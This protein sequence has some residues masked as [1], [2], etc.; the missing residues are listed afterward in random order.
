MPPE[1][2]LPPAEPPQLPGLTKQRARGP[3]RRRPSP[4]LSQ[5]PGGEQPRT[6]SCPPADSDPARFAWGRDPSIDPALFFSDVVGRSMGDERSSNGSVWAADR[7]LGSIAE[8]D[9]GR[10]SVGSGEGGGDGSEGVVERTKNGSGS[11]VARSSMGSNRLSE[12]AKRAS[13]GSEAKRVSTGSEE[14]RSKDSESKSGR[15]QIGSA[16]EAGGE[17]AAAGGPERPVS[18]VSAG[19]ESPVLRLTGG[20]VEGA[21]RRRLCTIL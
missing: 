18:G 4:R 19:R 21:P 17:P 2:E 8:S 11:D 16:S 13:T 7:R 1:L 5:L 9:G 14:T 12:D 15:E 20:E 10:G 3:P 6:V